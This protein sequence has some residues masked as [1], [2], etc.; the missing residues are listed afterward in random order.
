M[1]KVLVLADA[2]CGS[3]GFSNVS[4]H[5]LADIVA[6]GLYEIQVVGINYDGSGYDGRKFPYQ[7]IPATSALNDR[8]SDLYG[9]PR[10]LDMLYAGD[11]DIFF[12]IQDMSIISRYTKH[13]LKIQETKKFQTISYTPVDS[14]LS[15]KRQWVIDGVSQINYPVTYTEWGKKEIL[16]QAPDLENRLKVCYHGTDLTE[17]FQLPKEARDTH[18]KMGFDPNGNSLEGKFV[19]LNVNR[20]QIRKDYMRTFATFSEFKK[21]VP[22]AFLLVLAQNRDQGGDLTV[23]AS[24][25]GLTFGKDWI[26]PLDYRAHLVCPAEMINVMYNVADVTFSSSL[27]EGFGLSSLETMC[28]GTPAVFPDH[29]ALT[30]I[31]GGDGERGRLVKAGDTPGNHVC[32]GAY[33]SSLVRPAINIEDAVA[34]L[35]WVHDGGPEV[36]VMKQRAMEWAVEHTWGKINQFW[37]ERFAHACETAER[38]ENS[39]KK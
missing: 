33:D 2:P 27:G 31:F 36:E 8:Y 28:T 26:L 20:N 12:I 5:I 3:S 35:K 17:F 9:F 16:K 37:I 14:D 7:I 11:Y 29:T 19:V 23:I 18:R 15:T 4:R 38:K 30:E 10:A 32:Y 22:E 34:K 24:Q 1:K 6:T 25:F 21:L 13:I 39:K